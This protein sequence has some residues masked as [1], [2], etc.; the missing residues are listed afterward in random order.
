MLDAVIGDAGLTDHT[1]NLRSNSLCVPIQNH[2]QSR[3]YA[4]QQRGN[5]ALCELPM[6]ADRIS[7]VP[8]EGWHALGH[9][10]M[11]HK[12]CGLLL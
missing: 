2:N 3:R 8:T 4:T 1:G 11:T 10:E 12:P 5:L 7:T 6:P 9:A